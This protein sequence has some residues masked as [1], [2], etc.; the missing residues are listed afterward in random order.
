LLIVDSL[1]TGDFRLVIESL[2]FHAAAADY[3]SSI[4]T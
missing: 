3:Q 2:D 4:T 1:M